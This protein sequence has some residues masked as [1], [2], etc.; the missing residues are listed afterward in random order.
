MNKCLLHDL[1]RNKSHGKLIERGIILDFTSAV[2]KKIIVHRVGNKS[3]NEG[4][5]FSKDPLELNDKTLEELVFNYFLT[6]FQK[7]TPMLKF[8][9]SSSIELNEVYNYAIQLFRNNSNFTEQSNNIAK[10]LYEKSAHPMIKSG[11]VYI[12]HFTGCIFEG[13]CTDA[14]GIFKTENKDPYLK[15]VE[16][17]DNLELT[18]EHGINVN[19][20]DKGC[21]LY[22]VSHEDG[23]R[24][25]LVDASS[26]SSN[27]AK[28]WKE[29]FLNLISNNE[30]EFLTE[31]YLKMINSYT[32]KAFNNN[33]KIE[34]IQ[35]RAD[36]IDYFSKKDEFEF[37]DFASQVFVGTGAI[38]DFR[39]YKEQYEKI[40][41]VPEKDSFKIV[42][43][44]VEKMKKR[45]KSYIKLDTEID[46]AIKSV[47]S[48]PSKFIERGFDEHRN[49]S[50]YK[51]YFNEEL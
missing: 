26:K 25:A 48:G 11:E 17:N 10:H 41:T 42:P 23:L 31:T 37:N 33:Q 34:R 27:E 51:I 3:R 39:T 28:Y 6:P 14:L 32:Q 44:A 21:L 45:F 38:E 8:T 30:G 2:L 16:K 20:L 12:V 47:A 40:Q 22:N 9:H 18:Y 19:R 13:I 1:Y 46:I 4:I 24:V 5:Q 49:M 7:V 43:I 15:V 29:D 35:A 50:Y 36:A